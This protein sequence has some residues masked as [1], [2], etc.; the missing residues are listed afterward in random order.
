MK[1]ERIITTLEELEK[2]AKELKRE[3]MYE[4]CIMSLQ[5]VGFFEGGFVHEGIAYRIRIS[6]PKDIRKKKAEE[7]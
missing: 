1:G 3:Y 6:T 7:V 5:R 4:L 2:T